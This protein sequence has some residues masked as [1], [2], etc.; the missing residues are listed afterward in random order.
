MSC[1]FDALLEGV[2]VVAET[3]D[4]LL[5]G[6]SEGIEVGLNVGDPL[7]DRPVADVA[8]GPEDCLSARAVVLGADLLDLASVGLP[9]DFG[10]EK[11]ITVFSGRPGRSCHRVA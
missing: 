8:G 6:V 11:V 2:E 1:V 9:E 5:D 3:P 7:D 4:R 10:R